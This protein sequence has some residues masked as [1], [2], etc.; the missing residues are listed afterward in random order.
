MEK[1][2]PGEFVQ[3]K[4]VRDEREIEVKVRL[5]STVE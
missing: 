1:Y 2:D 5:G 3:L 4:V